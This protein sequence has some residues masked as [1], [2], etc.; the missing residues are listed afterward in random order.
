M[1]EPIRL[2]GR[3]PEVDPQK[4][5]ISYSG[6][7]PLVI[8]ELGIARAF[9]QKGIVP[10]AIAGASAG[11][12][13][14]FAHALDVRAGTGVALAAELLA[15]VSNALLGLDPFHVLGRLLV[16]REAI[17]SLGDNAVIGPL[18]RE[19]LTRVMGLDGVTTRTFVPPAYPKLLIATTDVQRGTSVWFSDDT[20]AEAVPVEEALIASSAIPGVFPWRVE[21]LGGADV[22]LADGGV[23]DNQPLSK[24][25]EQGCGTL[26]ACA[27]GPTAALPPP[28]NGLDNAFRVTNLMTRQCT[29]LEEDY[30]R[31]KLGHRGR[32]YH[33]HPIVDFPIHE[34]DFSPGLIQ[35]VMDDATAKTLD[36]LGKIERGEVTD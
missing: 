6:G 18:V 31:L 8:V 22:L 27:V 26:Y 24:L 5:G 7:G 23:V 4:I 25:V 21:R 10:A 30:V 17:K 35:Q 19:G 33:I 11:A 14:G 32:V 34:F 1:A 2:Q 3:T 12:L 9:V 36:W 20:P 15:H 29:K 28:A 13:A 16:E